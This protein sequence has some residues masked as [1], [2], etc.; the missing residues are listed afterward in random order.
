MGDND[1]SDDEKA[2]FRFA[3]RS[4]KPISSKNAKV[5]YEKKPVLPKVHKDFMPFEKPA[6]DIYLSSEY[7]HS[8]TAE[9]VIAYKVSG[10]PQK[11]FKRMQNGQQGY[12]SRLDLH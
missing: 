5:K 12:T 6:H 11:Q 1:I 4:A 9:E 10:L 7:T 2:L 3:V 8:I